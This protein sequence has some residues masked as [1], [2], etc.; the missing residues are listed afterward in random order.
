MCATRK[1]SPKVNLLNKDTKKSKIKRY[2]EKARETLLAFVL[3]FLLVP[4]FTISP[5]FE[6]RKYVSKVQRIFM[7]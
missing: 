4:R 7:D 2:K 1:F 5:L 3:H 6:I